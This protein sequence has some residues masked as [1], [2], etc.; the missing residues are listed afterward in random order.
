MAAHG[1]AR[2]TGDMDVLIRPE[3]AN[4]RRVVDALIASGAPVDAHGVS[5][6]DFERE[7]NVYQ[8]ALPPRR[9][10]CSPACVA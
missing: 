1:V 9:I 10:E 8:M 5:A 7:G 4:A 3:A 2:A 6:A